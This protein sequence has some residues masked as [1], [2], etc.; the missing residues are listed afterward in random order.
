MTKKSKRGSFYKNKKIN[1]IEYI[2]VNNKLV[3]KREPYGKKILL[4]T[5]SDTMTMILLDHYV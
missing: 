3:S 2:N 1:N 4:N 5:L